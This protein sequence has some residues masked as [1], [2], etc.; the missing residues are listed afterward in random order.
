MIKKTQPIILWLTLIV[1]GISS[2]SYAEVVDRI[3]AIVNNEIITLSQL[4][5][6]TLPYKRN[7]QAS[8]NSIEQ[9]KQL[10][11][12]LETDLLNQLI[13]RS[14]TSQEAV[15]YGI[16][17]GEKDVDGAMENFMASNKMDLEQLEI[18]LASDGLSLKDYRTKMKGEILQSRLI[19]RAV[20]SQVIITQKEIKAYYDSHGEE[21]AGVK[22]YHLR[23]IITQNETDMRVVL[24]KLEKKFPFTKLAKHYSVGTNAKEGG[25]LGIFD[26]DNLSEEI[27]K[28]IQ[29]LGKNDHSKV[30][31]SGGAYQIFYVE[32][33]LMEGHKT[34]DQAADQIENILYK[35]QAEKRFSE[36]IDSLKE[37][38]HI[39]I[40]L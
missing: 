18:A 12:T 13:E 26:I 34:I 35:E 38:A 30:L 8:Q 28:N 37:N 21:F 22:K 27:K 17:V 7:I 1:I 24:E 39:K 20:R 19:S 2:I 16:S 5:K 3:V 25:D 14:L 40:M 6:A 23:N 4:N 31:E 36:W 10:V 11:A 15:K 33:I 29:P 32:D 9:K